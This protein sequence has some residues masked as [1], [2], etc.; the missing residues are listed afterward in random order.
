MWINQASYVI[1]VVGEI[2]KS[3]KFYERGEFYNT[4]SSGACVQNI[5]LKA[6]SI[7]L[8]ACWVSAFEEEKIN[9][10]LSIKSP[11]KPMAVI[12]IGYPAETPVKPK[13]EDLFDQTFINSWG[14]KVHDLDLKYQNFRYLERSLSIFEKILN[15]L[16]NIPNYLKNFFN[17]F[18]K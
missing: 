8:G 14:Q 17:N 11:N 12:P 7:G 6:H 5:L 15:W 16:N 1:V 4:L 10:V 18:N 3:N 13:K 9:D 2:K